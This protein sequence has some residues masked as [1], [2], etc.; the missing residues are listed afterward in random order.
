MDAVN[1]AARKVFDLLWTPFAGLPGWV[2]LFAL[3]VVFGVAALLAMKYTTNPK[4]VTRFKD[5]SQ[6]H[7]LAIKL[8]RDSFTV[9]V[10]SLVKAVLW[11]GGYLAEQFKPMLLLLVP[12]ALLFAQM[13][14]RLGLRPLDVG[15]EVLVTVEVDPVRV[16][17]IPEVAVELP[18]G[19]T[20]PR[21]AVREPKL[22]RVVFAF[23]PTVA[24]RHELRFR[25]GSEVVIKTFD[26]GDLPGLPRVS[27]VRS[28]G[29][30]DQLLYPSEPAFSSD[31]QF[32]RI[33]FASPVRPLLLLGLDLSF[34]SEAGMMLV[35][36]LLT[37]VV[38]FALKD[39]FGVTI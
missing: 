15:K 29:F 20:Q 4:R 5:R 32:Q 30:W 25:I 11:S 19:V 16:T 26:A 24:G 28:A 39:L 37:I 36:V 14:M 9:V 34:G 2:G 17:G 8:F 6:G 22:K 7:I 38:A 21:P 33:A 12:F 18:A 27:P 3:G 13:E 23:T 31:S 10:G 35:F 1:A